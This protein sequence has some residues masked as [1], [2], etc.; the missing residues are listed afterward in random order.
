MFW[1]CKE[2]PRFYVTTASTTKRG[3]IREKAQ[4]HNWSSF[5]I[6]PAIA[7]IL[8][9]ELIYDII[10]MCSNQDNKFRKVFAYRFTLSL[11]KDV[12]LD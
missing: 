8:G 7:Q 12:Y 5:Y 4:A 10:Y 6:T 3:I 11:P 9:P 2:I 1:I